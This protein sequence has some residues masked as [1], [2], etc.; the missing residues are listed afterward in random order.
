[1]IKDE[2][3][4]RVA[5]AEAM[6]YE[7]DRGWLPEDVSGKDQGF[8]ILSRHPDSGSIRFIEVKGRAGVGIVGLTSNEYKTAERLRQDYWLYIVFDCKAQPR[9][10][11]VKDPVRLS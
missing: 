5:M 11:L 4:E 10:H 3:V 9:L 8:D 6:R 2:E 1:M 7:N